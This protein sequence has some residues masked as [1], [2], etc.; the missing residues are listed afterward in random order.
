M[1]HLTD[2]YPRVTMMTEKKLLIHSNSCWVS[3]AV[4]MRETRMSVYRVS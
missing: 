2:V 1:T 3:D 4:T